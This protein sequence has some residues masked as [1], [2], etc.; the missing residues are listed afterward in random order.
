MNTNLRTVLFLASVALIVFNP[1]AL[2]HTD[3]T[4][5]Q[6]RDLIDFTNDLIVVDVRELYEYCDAIG[7]IP[8]ALNYPWN[9]GVLQ[10]RYEELPM[11]GPVLV[12]CRSGG[13]S[14]RAANFLDS[15]GFSMVYDMLGGMG[16]WIWETAPC[17]YAGGSGT[18]G[19]PYQIAIAEDLMALGDSPEDYDK[20]FILTAD[21]DL[22][23]NLPGGRV[24][25]QA[26]IAPDVNDARHFQGTAFSGSLDGNGYKIRNLSIHNIAGD[27]VGLFG[28][29]E[30]NG[31]VHNLGLEGVLISGLDCIG[32]LAGDS[33]GNITNCYAT[34]KVF[35]EEHSRWIGGLV[36]A[37]DGSIKDCHA[38][39]D[40]TSGDMSLAL[41]G[42]V[43]TNWGSIVNCYSTGNVSGANNNFDIGGLAG[44]CHW[45]SIIKDSHARGQ[46]S[47]G[48]ECN[49]IG[50]LVGNAEMHNEITNCYSI[51][52]ITVGNYGRSI[53]GLVGNNSNSEISNCYTIS[54]VT[55]GYGS[56]SF[57]GLVGSASGI[58][59]DCYAIGNVSGY[60]Y[61]GGLVGQLHASKVTNCY[62]AGRVS[63]S[64]KT[65]FIGGLAASITEYVL[66]N[67]CF[68]N[69]ET[70][71]QSFS[72]SGIGLTT[73]QMQDIQTYQASSWD[74]AGDRTDGT[75]DIWQMPE[76]GGYPELTIFS[77]NY[78][79]HKLNGAG[80]PENPYQIATAE[81]LGAIF[82]FDR[83]ASYK[84]V[85]D[86]DL[87]GITWGN[88]P[89]PKVNGFFEGNGHLIKNLTIQGGKADF[90][91]G[92]VGSIESNGKIQNLGLDDVSI[93]AG[94]GSYNIAGLAG[95]NSGTITNCYVNGS[96]F[97]G[98]EIRY[99][100]VLVGRSSYPS[101]IAYCYAAG[102]ISQ[103]HNAEFIGGLVGYNLTY[104]NQCY[105][106]V[107]IIS[108]GNFSNLGGLVGNYEN[109]EAFISDCFWDMQK[110][111]ISENGGGIGLT[112]AQMQ[113]PN[114]FMD[115]GWDFIN[116]P[117]GPS[118]IW[119]QPT[120]GGLPI[121]WWQLPESQLPP[122]PMYAGG[123]GETN[124]PYLLS[125]AN[126]LNHIGYNPRLMAAHFKLT[127]D[128]DLTNDEFFIIGN[129]TFPF[130]G[131]FDGNSHTISNFS[132]T[133][134][135]KDHAGLFGYIDN[136]HTEVRNLGLIDPNV[137]STTEWKVG[138]LVGQLTN[139]IITGCYV[140]GG[141]IFGNGIVGGLVGSND[142][143]ISDCHADCSVFSN[144]CVG[145]LVGISG[146]TIINCTSSGEVSGND[147]TGGLVGTN[148]G[149]ISKCDS[150]GSI[151]GRND[152]G[153]LVG[154]N[155]KIIT[156]CRSSAD[157]VGIE[158]VGGL[159]GE[160][161]GTIN[162]SYATY[163]TS[164]NTIV[165]GLVGSNGYI[166][167]WD[168]YFES[169]GEILNCYSTGIA[170]GNSSVGGLVGLLKVGSV[171]SSFWDIQ[172][173]G[174]ASSDGGTGKTTVEMQT[175]STFLDAGW[176]FVDE[177]ANGTEDIWWIDEGKDYPR[178]WWELI[179]EN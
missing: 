40:V 157:V 32:G 152:V 19:D 60:I 49:W 122:L 104:I 94:D 25:I 63:S 106:S 128:I 130:V 121:L 117:D 11:H 147:S 155:S 168:V 4:A 153:G 24:F 97:A 144:R 15:K 6:A 138:S 9:S 102:S 31:R 56:R 90:L 101:K 91:L 179:T 78:Q 93:T 164:V 16:A 53:G 80:T 100:G 21:I 151:S 84:L 22:D 58:I 5:E 29:I 148:N 176:D 62:A 109:S 178:L 12:V 34:G 132:Y 77:E 135:N 39:V 105:A 127:N 118:D 57:G 123:S 33:G 85:D 89:I 137:N 51:G 115:A 171:A 8:S 159:V 170:S 55:G 45:G 169:P 3:V 174:Q 37:N 107:E 99:L 150:V 67:Q 76:G 116:A 154:S 114:I 175:A 30:T 54:N 42:L 74:M 23:P 61:L 88:A 75:S 167:T 108:R 72:A 134:T 161:T 133:S 111:G 125:T 70:S 163:N 43:G 7:H 28:T 81:D 59:S 120:G 10:A 160:N 166:Q 14:N 142:G 79:P 103:G 129:E 110:S 64:I 1:C 86:I 73:A 87:T 95:S 113:D 82:R 96:V 165:G 162:N 112:T 35:G 146:G 156:N 172:T 92:L 140:Q 158:C 27:Y 2:A 36:G 18:E 68:W 98:E 149:E 48:S 46:V 41:G 124:D 38:S 52:T 136:P 71:G 126:D 139:G 66:V 69:V 13:R 143:T 26:V 65:S 119:A 131:V 173:S 20:H 44:S 141:S 145:G 50:G 177:T 83:T 47:T 17:K